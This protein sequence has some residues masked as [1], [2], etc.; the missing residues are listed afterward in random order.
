MKRL[1]LLSLTICSL[2]VHAQKVKT[3]MVPMWI[4]FMPKKMLPADNLTFSCVTIE[5]SANE[6]YRTTGNGEGI[7]WNAAT[8]HLIAGFKNVGA[9]Q[10][11]AIAVTIRTEPYSIA[12]KSVMT[13]T[14]PGP[15]GT[16]V[17]ACS[18]DLKAQYILNA[19]VVSNGDTIMK[20]TRN[21]GA[22]TTMNYPNTVKPMG[23]PMSF[24]SSAALEAEYSKRNHDI[25][26]VTRK[27]CNEDFITFLSDTLNAAFGYPAAKVFFEIATA[28]SKS[29]QYDDLDSAKDYITR[30]M[31]SVTAHCR[32]NDTRNWTFESSRSLVLK[33]I[34]IWEKALLEESTD[35]KA[36]IHPELAG[37]I[38]LNLALAYMMLDDYTKAEQ[39]Y[40]KCAVDP[41][42][43]NGT[44]RNV[45]FIQQNYLPVFKARY[46]IHKSR[47]G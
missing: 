45:L 14:N 19:V 46:E 8:D 11:P 1:T 31:D 12:Q 23:S 47:L 42:L 20:I 7:N 43:S 13:T 41:E 38:R 15:N 34:T 37:Y 30:A 16:Q 36:R 3:D 24:P 29:F 17:N 35:K 18:Y 32:A 33:A 40:A 44:K 4:T 27:K 21:Q 2:A 26:V 10:N 25:M 39:L 5:H 22:L 28:K 6:K 9:A